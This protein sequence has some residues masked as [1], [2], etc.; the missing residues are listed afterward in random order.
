MKKMLSIV[1]TL[2]MLAVSAAAFA[3]GPVITYDPAV[4]K[5][6]GVEAA[7]LSLEDYGLWVDI[8]SEMLALEVSEEEAAAGTVAAFSAGDGSYAVSVGFSQVLD[9]E[10]NCFEDYASLSACYA[11]MGVTEMEIAD[12]N[13]LYAMT[14]LLADYDMMGAVYLFDEGWVLAFNFSG[15][16][17]EALTAVSTAI[18]SSIRPAE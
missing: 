14:Y 10:G 5:A 16:S 3:E 15:A 1:L 2:A 7:T 6:L 9:E 11:E 4:F 17:N 13:G 8:P 18:I 12:I